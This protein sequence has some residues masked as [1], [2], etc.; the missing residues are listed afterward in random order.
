MV[1]LYKFKQYLRLSKKLSSILRHGVVPLSLR[2]LRKKLSFMIDYRF[3]GGYSSPPFSLHVGVTDFCNLRC[4]MC[5]YANTLSPYSRLNNLGMMDLNLF[6]KLIREIKGKPA[7]I[8]TGGEPLLH[9]EIEYFVEEVKKNGMISIMATNGTLLK[10]KARKLV[11]AG[12]DYLMVSVDG[13]EKIHD[14]VRGFKGTFKKAVDG[15]KEINKC[16]NGPV[17]TVNFSVSDFNYLNMKEFFEEVKKWGIDIINFNMLWQRTP[18]MI[19]AHNK[20]YPQFKVSSLNYQ[21]NNK[22]IDFKKFEEDILWIRS[23]KSDKVVNFYPLLSYE[24][25]VTYY[26]IPEKFLKAHLAK[27]PWINFHISPNGDVVLCGDIIF[28]NLNKDNVNDIWNNNKFRLFRNK[29]KKSN[30]FPICARCC[31]FFELEALS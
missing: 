24:D 31:G 4:K 30:A 3:R 27:C 7:V 1:S 13:T 2:F 6:K 14:G 16:K 28:G 21:Y 20:L 11:D 26:T 23:R 10:Q 5:F 9:P 8:L 19:K 15:I 18:K 29:I 12:L 17:I 22:K 25:I